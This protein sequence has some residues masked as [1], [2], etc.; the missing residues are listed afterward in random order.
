MSFDYEYIDNL[1]V[2]ILFDSYLVNKNN[3]KLILIYSLQK[4]LKKKIKFKVIK[5]SIIN[6]L[7]IKN[8]EELDLFFS[9]LNFK[10]CSKKTFINKK[11][12]YDQ[13]KK[14]LKESYK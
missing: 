6:N 10:P 3:I 4:V 1:E 9:K 12:N 5:I 7:G 14:S 13:I 2:K 11:C 8:Y